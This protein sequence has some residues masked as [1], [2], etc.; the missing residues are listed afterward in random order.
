MSKP[1]KLYRRAAAGSQYA[2]VVGLIAVVALLGVT[3][4]G[5]NFK[6]VANRAANSICSADGQSCAAPVVVSSTPPGPVCGGDGG[7]DT[8]F[9]ASGAGANNMVWKILPLSSG[10]YLIGGSFTTYNGTARANFA[11]INADGS[12]DTAYPSSGTIGGGLVRAIVQQ[13]D[14]KVVV[15]GHF[16]TFNGVARNRV[17][18]LNSDG[19]LDTSFLNT[20]TGASASV[21]A[22][23]LQPD[24][25][26]IIGGDF[27]SYNGVTRGNLARINSDG[28]LDTS[29]LN[30]G[31]GAN[32]VI[33]AIALQSDGKLVV[34][35]SM[36]NYNGTARANLA[37]VN[38]DGSLDT[39][40]M[41]SNTGTDN[42][43]NAI[44]IQPDGK[45][46]IVGFFVSYNS[47]T[48][49]GIARLNS[50]GTLD[51]SFLSSG[52]GAGG[53]V[54]DVALAGDG[55]IYISGSFT[56][57]NGVSRGMIARLNADG[58]LDTSF[59]NSGSGANSQIRPLILQPSDGKPIIGGNFTTYN[60]TTRGMIA[61]LG[62]SP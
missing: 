35:G 34:A 60:G 61:R 41:A 5:L 28:S 45:I 37:R 8:T 33:D 12:L 7:L 38:A 26:L 4:L 10:K 2:L 17:A 29:F 46:I 54:Y 1:L 18:R 20:G 58:S 53:T 55:K 50:N 43:I 51:T 36:S 23:V 22:M 27:L 39:G 30:T 15:G 25:Q 56:T 47:T 11:Q 13:S 59:L 42:Q 62:C 52:A 31:S 19:T 48:R 44:T 9:L 3:Q 16:T 14:G 40:F 6:A 57:Y 21:Q 24:G 32:N 49:N